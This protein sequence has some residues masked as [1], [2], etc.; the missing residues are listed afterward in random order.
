MAHAGACFGQKLQFFI[1][2]MN[3]VRVPH[4]WADPA[5]R[6]HESQRAHALAFEHIVLLVFR[7]AQVGVQAD[8]VLPREHGALPQKFR[9]D[10]ERRARRERDLP[11][12][13]KRRVVI[14]FNEACGVSHDLIDR[15]H[16]RI[17]R[18]TA[19]LDGQIHRAA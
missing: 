15:L 16:N 11:H 10:R 4:V 6:L 1:V 5:E 18:Q 9:R 12:G 3:A 19:I 2:K 7:L 14:R 8:M 17:W 13:T